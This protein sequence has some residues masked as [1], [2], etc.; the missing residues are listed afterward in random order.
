MDIADEFF[1]IVDSLT[2]NA[3]AVSTGGHGKG[4][5]DA[6]AKV[7]KAIR[8]LAVRTYIP[9]DGQFR[10]MLAERWGKPSTKEPS[11]GTYLL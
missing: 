4:I 3:V 9:I 2:D 1:E 6:R 7:R 5:K 11:S 8:T 10:D